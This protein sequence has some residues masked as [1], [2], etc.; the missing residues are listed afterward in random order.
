MRALRFRPFARCRFS[1]AVACLVIA[2]MLPKIGAAEEVVSRPDAAPTFGDVSLSLGLGYLSQTITR[3]YPSE[4]SQSDFSLSLGVTSPLSRRIMWGLT[5]VIS[6]PTAD[7][8][9]YSLIAAKVRLR[10]Y[11]ALNRRQRDQVYL[12]IG[13]LLVAGGESGRA[14]HGGGVEVGIGVDVFVGQTSTV[15]VEAGFAVVGIAGRETEYYRT[16]TAPLAAQAL[17]ITESP[18]RTLLHVT[19]G[20]RF[21]I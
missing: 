7:V 1:L 8:G 3:G 4:D 11:P 13:G 5:T 9:A 19:L 20:T 16:F 14:N 15:F 21:G 10:F 2:A 6:T 17:H 12:S 18:A